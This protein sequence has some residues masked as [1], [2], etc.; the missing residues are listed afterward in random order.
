[1]KKWVFDNL[2]CP[3]CPEEKADLA[4]VMHK[5][6]A[7]DIIDGELMCHVCGS[8]HPIQDGVAMV[9][10]EKRQPLPI[11]NS[12]F[13]IG[14]AREILNQKRLYFEM[15]MEGYIFE[16][17]HCKLNENFEAD[18]QKRKRWAFLQARDHIK[19]RSRMS[20]S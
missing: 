12:L 7:G 19:E 9:L 1:M 13:L 20:S 18:R 15:I 17:H 8:R 10:P 16:L 3:G 4:L 5:E 6:E 11:D 14:K 2:I